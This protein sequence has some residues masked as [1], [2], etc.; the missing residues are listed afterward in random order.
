MVR[1]CCLLFAFFIGGCA[2]T[3]PPS[4]IRAVTRTPITAITDETLAIDYAAERSYRQGK[5]P[6]RLGLAF[7]GGGTKA[8]M[9]AHGVLHGLHNAGILQRVDAIS[10]VSG[11]SYAA[12]W[13]F[14]KLIAS[15]DE[16]F[17][18]S[19]IFDD[20]LPT[21]WTKYDKLGVDHPLQIAMS[22]AENREYLENPDPRVISLPAC[23][24]ENHFVARQG[25]PFRWQAHLAR[26]PDVFRETPTPLT[27]DRQ[28]RPNKEIR[29][30][31][32]AGLFIEPFTQLFRHK[33]SIPRLYQWGIE[34]AWGL[35]PAIRNENAVY[36]AKRES[37]KWQYTNAAPLD[38]S[39]PA[40][41]D[42]TRVNWQALRSL[43]THSATDGFPR[44]V[45]LWILNTN[46]GGKTPDS[47]ANVRRIFELTP[48]GTGGEEFGY[49][50]SIDAPLIEDL[51]TSVRASAGFA[52]AQGLTRIASKIVDFVSFFVPGARWGVPVEVIKTSGEKIKLRLSDGGG[53]ENLGLISLLRRGVKDIILVDAAE[54]VEGNMEDLCAVKEALGSDILLNFPTLQNFDQVCSGKLAY[55]LSDWKSPVV[56]GTATWKRDGV[57]VRESR[58]WLI[59][60]AWNQNLLRKTYNEKKCGNIGYADC[61]LTVFYAHNTVFNIAGKDDPSMNM[62]FPQLPTAGST[63]NASSYLFWGYRELGRS[64]ARQLDWD[65]TDGRLQ[66]INP[67]CYQRAATRIKKNRP[68]WQNDRRSLE[69]CPAAIATTAQSK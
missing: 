33:S 47:K 8:A 62:A 42:P 61:F 34:R 23:P 65:T 17:P 26:W 43:Y 5:S 56:R 54:D 28:G 18:S 11:G 31:L 16:G 58:I 51:G 66:S 32:F 25:D 48:F 46:S 60:A 12:Y 6:I 57:A 22:R 1:G 15:R 37:D 35:N 38:G 2:T 44:Q 13:Y 45:P 21:W 20:C 67:E 59:K 53:A 64:M 50:N 24:D 39:H 30:G 3:T 4:Q 63:I 49:V 36:R 27:G 14:T 7:S 41:V 29:E 10:T 69:P 55:N 68:Y 40:R 52:D 19:G 9:F